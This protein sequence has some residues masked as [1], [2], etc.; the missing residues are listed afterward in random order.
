MLG[1]KKV[2]FQ[3]N[4]EILVICSEKILDLQANKR[5]HRHLDK[6]RRKNKCYL[7]CHSHTWL[8]RGAENNL[9]KKEK[10]EEQNRCL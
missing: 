5:V 7:C 3:I 10:V 9:T 1:D 2:I 4:M 8:R 6:Q